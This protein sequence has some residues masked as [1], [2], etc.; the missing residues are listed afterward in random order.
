MAVRGRLAFGQDPPRPGRGQ[1]EAKRIPWPTSLPDDLRCDVLDLRGVPA[2]P[3]PNGLRCYDLLLAGSAIRS[4]PADLKVERKL[5]LANCRELTAL[6]TGLT[7]GSLD[8]SGCV[9]LT[10]LPEGL[11]VWFLNLQGC[12]GLRTWPQRATIR[13]GTLNLRDCASLN[14]LPDYLGSLAALNLRGCVSLKRLPD[15]LEVTGPLEIARSGVVDGTGIPAPLMEQA[16]WRWMGVPIERRI[17]FE[18]GSITAAEIL[19]ERNAERR[20]VMIDRVGYTRFMREAN[21]KVRDADRDAGGERQLLV[22]PLPDDEDLVTLSCHCPSTGNRY[23]IRVPPATKSCHAA[24][25]WIAGFD[26]PNDY[27]PNK[28]T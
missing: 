7:C 3:W 17:V 28:E 12:L 22:I 21:A 23:V 16:Q 13:A 2:L 6:P 25:A 24:A 11:D 26:D 5:D 4:L 19:A 8:V 20:R 1:R 9:S 15:N 18:P 10:E 27:R 14:E